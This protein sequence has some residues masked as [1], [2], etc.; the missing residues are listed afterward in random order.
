[1]KPLLDDGPVSRRS[2]HELGDLAP[3]VVRAAMLSRIPPG[4]IGNRADVLGAILL[5]SLS[6][7]AY[8][9]REIL[10]V[11]GGRTVD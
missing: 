2:V 9:S 4:G 11:D 10:F 5:L 7:A 6:L 8:V 1:M 3:S